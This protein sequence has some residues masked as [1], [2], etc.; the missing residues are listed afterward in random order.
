MNTKN[1]EIV[2]FNIIHT[3]D[4]YDEYIKYVRVSMYQIFL[5]NKL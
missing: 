3:I 5:Q 4:V 2:V 1:C